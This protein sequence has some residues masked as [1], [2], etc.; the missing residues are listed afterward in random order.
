[1]HPFGG[2]GGGCLS[3]CPDGDGRLLLVAVPLGGV[4]GEREEAAGPLAGARKG[5]GAE[6]PLPPNAAPGPESVAHRA[7]T[8]PGATGLPC[9]PSPGPRPTERPMPC[10]TTHPQGIGF[11]VMSAGATPALRPGQARRGRHQRE[12]HGA[13]VETPSVVLQPP[14]AA[15]PKVTEGMGPSC[16]GGFCSLEKGCTEMRQRSDAEEGPVEGRGIVAP[17]RDTAVAGAQVR[18]I[19]VPSKR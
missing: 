4:R 17:P 9:G 12:R 11:G 16:C 1:M 5:R 2:G 8:S 10:T 3:D 13:T 14:S 15:P 6:S 7:E 18:S 19:K